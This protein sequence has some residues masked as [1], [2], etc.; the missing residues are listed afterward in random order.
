MFVVLEDDVLEDK[1]Q[2]AAAPLLM[3]PG[4]A[5]P[6]DRRDFFQLLRW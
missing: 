3:G 4:R 5:R 6:L 1:T 2:P